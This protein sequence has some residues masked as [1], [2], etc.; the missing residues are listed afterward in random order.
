MTKEF[1]AEN[2]NAIA[3]LTAEVV[4]AYVGNNPVPAANLPAL[5]SS[6]HR[7]LTGLG[8]ATVEE[9][10]P[11]P[12]VNPKRSV[13]P[14]HIVC[15]ECGKKFKSL[16][17]HITSRHDVTPEEYRARWELPADYPMVAPDYAAE[18]S[19]LALEAGLGRKPGE[20]KS[21]RKKK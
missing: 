17:R 21:A 12:A 5:I 11:E 1:V 20:K 10:K 9:G 18:R 2:P 7:A 13:R 6:I 15:L 8:G 4:S 19:K 3:E 16:K 14:D